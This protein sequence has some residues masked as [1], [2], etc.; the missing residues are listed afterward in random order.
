MGR[1]YYRPTHVQKQVYQ[2]QLQKIRTYQQHVQVKQ[3]IKGK[4]ITDKF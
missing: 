2:V 4:D 1:D 3:L